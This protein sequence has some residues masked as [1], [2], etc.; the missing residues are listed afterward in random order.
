[1]DT[2][3]GRLRA[4]ARQNREK[5]LGTQ[6]RR[7]DDLVSKAANQI[8]VMSFGHAE[9]AHLSRLRRDCA[10]IVDV[11]DAAWGVTLQSARGRSADKQGSPDREPGMS[12]PQE[13]SG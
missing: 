11:T 2:R 3:A 9:L 13:Q 12:L 10:E 1:M 4:D 5:I 8:V 7:V 6:R